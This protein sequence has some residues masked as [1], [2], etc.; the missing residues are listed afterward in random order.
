MTTGQRLLCKEF[1]VPMFQHY[2][3]SPYALTCALLSLPDTPPSARSGRS[4]RAS[5]R[6]CLR[7]SPIGWTTTTT[8]T[9]ATTTTTTNHNNNRNHNNNTIELI[10]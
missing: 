8:T 7:G 6:A 10:V 4:R 1:G 3:L 2:A 9:A 5:S